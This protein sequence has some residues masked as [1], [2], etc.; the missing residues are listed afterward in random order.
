MQKSGPE[1]VRALSNDE[2]NGPGRLPRPHEWDLTSKAG[3][4]QTQLVLTSLWF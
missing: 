4:V 3:L 1:G 2:R